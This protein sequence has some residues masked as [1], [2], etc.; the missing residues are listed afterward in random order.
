MMPP[1]FAHLISIYALILL[2]EQLRSLKHFEEDE[3]KHNMD[4]LE[5]GKDAVNVVAFV[6]NIYNFIIWCR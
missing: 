6:L 3:E 5:L 1:F 4:L 2:Q